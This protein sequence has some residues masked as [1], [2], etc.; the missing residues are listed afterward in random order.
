MR[1]RKNATLKNFTNSV[2]TGLLN[3]LLNIALRAVFVKT[4]GK[5]YLGVNGLFTNVLGFL[6]L[7]ELG[8][9]A[10][11]GFNLYKPLAENDI[12][13]IQALINFYRSAY[14]VVATIILVISVILIPFLPYIAKGADNVEHLTLI[15]CIYIFNT[16]SSYLITYKSTIITADQ[17]MYKLT[18]LN[19]F[20]N[21]I[22]MI[23]QAIELLVI[24]DYIGYLIVA[25]VI[26]LVRNIYVNY[27]TNKNYPYI[28]KKN[29]Q[30]LSKEEKSHIFM[31]IRALMYHK[32]GDVVIFQTDSIITS[33]IIN[34]EAVGLVSNYNMIINIILSFC[35][36]FYSSMNPSFGNLLATTDVEYQ[37]KVFD[38]INFIGYWLNSFTS[39]CLFFL[40]DPFIP[41]WLK[42]EDY[43]LNKFV[44][45]L[46]VINY[47]MLVM[48]IPVQIP[49]HAA[50]MYEFDKLSPVIESI[51]NLIISIIGAKALGIAGIYIGTFFSCIVP[52][53]WSPIVVYNRIF[54]RSASEYFKEY[55]LRT[56]LMFVSGGTIFIIISFVKFSNLYINFIFI[57][58]LCVVV[59]NAF[60]VVIYHKNDNFRYALESGKKYINKFL[61]MI[62]RG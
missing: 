46:L 10:A 52:T 36:S 33:A 16:V 41:I 30:H 47:Y 35:Q 4:L 61:S 28:K 8:I 3:T 49:K 11:I 6:S 37:K 20:A 9:G 19:F 51:I 32:I 59:H 45:F 18:R 39:V 50:G 38:R 48:R 23:F 34:V 56:L 53:T 40:L 26:G 57:A 55:L 15:Y 44:V 60:I 42:S 58:V 24:K 21:I 29:D 1:S 31:K 25:S 13:K 62:K 17:N 2:I 43:I 14:R 12:P 54:K 5:E 7:A 22:I 27:Y